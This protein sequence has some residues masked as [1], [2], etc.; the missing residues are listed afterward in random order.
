[1]RATEAKRR[2]PHIAYVEETDVTEL[3]K[4]RQ[5]LNAHRTADQP[6][7]TLLPF[8]MRALV[9]VLPQFPQITKMILEL[10]RS[11][12]NSTAISSAMFVLQMQ[13]CGEPLNK[14]VGGFFWFG[15]V[16]SRRPDITNAGTKRTDHTTQTCEHPLFS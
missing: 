5:D 2:I 3:E 6:K 12:R 8:L 16:Y 13:L 1:M 9:R 7:L 10:R 14:P 4:L 11:R 15:R